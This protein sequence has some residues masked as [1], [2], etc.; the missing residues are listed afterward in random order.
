MALVIFLHIFYQNRVGEG[1]RGVTL[2]G[3]LWRVRVCH[4]G[5]V[6]RE[7]HESHFYD[8]KSAYL[9]VMGLPLNTYKLGVGLNP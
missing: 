1:G 4:C 8:K 9:E 2:D 7:I 5:L 6:G 3:G